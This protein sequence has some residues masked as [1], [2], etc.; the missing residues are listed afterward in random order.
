MT[1]SHIHKYIYVNLM[2][3]QTDRKIDSSV[4]IYGCDRYLKDVC[5]CIE[6]PPFCGTI[7]FTVKSTNLTHEKEIT[8][9]QSQ[10]KQSW[11]TL[12]RH[13]EE[14]CAMLNTKHQM[15]MK[16]HE[17]NFFFFNFLKFFLTLIKLYWTMSLKKIEKFPHFY[18]YVRSISL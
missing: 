13:V 18:T 4:K 2:D 14:S 12:E 10:W 3:R 9:I 6:A 5:I 1:H 17:D 15:E 11:E 8:S 16:V 7:Q